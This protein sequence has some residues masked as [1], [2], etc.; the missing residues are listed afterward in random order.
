MSASYARLDSLRSCG[1][2]R[3]DTVALTTT[4]FVVLQALVPC[5]VWAAVCPQQKRAST[6]TITALRATPSIDR[7]WRLSWLPTYP[8]V[9]ARANP[10]IPRQRRVNL[11]VVVEGDLDSVEVI[12]RI[13]RAVVSGV[14]GVRPGLAISITALRHRPGCS[15]ELTPHGVAKCYEELA[16]AL[17]SPARLA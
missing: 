1:S 17:V 3:R 10:P 8:R 2:C 13:Q 6:E 7:H 15:A 9:C 14:A 11:V 12:D 4:L 5:N 16:V